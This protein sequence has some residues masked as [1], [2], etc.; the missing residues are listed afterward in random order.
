WS[1]LYHGGKPEAWVSSPDLN[2]SVK[3]I[4]QNSSRAAFG[5]ALCYGV[6]GTY[7]PELKRAVEEVRY[8]DPVTAEIIWS[9]DTPPAIDREIIIEAGW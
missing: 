1:E 9:G 3:R 7:R 8:R 6:S 2:G 5:L 4:D